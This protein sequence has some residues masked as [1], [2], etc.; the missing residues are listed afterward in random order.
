MRIWV[1][2][3]L[4]TV[5]HLSR[6]ITAIR[7]S[8]SYLRR[9]PRTSFRDPPF[10]DPLPHTYVLAAKE[11]DVDIVAKCEGKRWT[12]GDLWSILIPKSF[13]WWS[14]PIDGSVDTDDNVKIAD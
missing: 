6:T 8:P 9:I 2:R 4:S 3:Q 10:C 7:P 1:G 12:V 11:G 5:P 14:A 13:D